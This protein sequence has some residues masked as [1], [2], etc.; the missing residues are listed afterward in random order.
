[1]PG[2]FKPNIGSVHPS[3]RGR[4]R[5]LKVVPTRL[6]SVVSRRGGIRGGRIAQPAPLSRKRTRSPSPVASG[7]TLQK[8][9]RVASESPHNSPVSQSSDGHPSF[10]PSDISPSPFHQD[11][12]PPDDYDDLYAE[13][14]LDPSS[15][16][17]LYYPESP[18]HAITPR[19]SC[20][21]SVDYERECG[22]EGLNNS[23]NTHDKQ[24][25]PVPPMARPAL[26]PIDNP[27]DPRPA[28]SPPPDP[29]SP[30]VSI[31]DLPKRQMR[32][33]PLQ[34]FISSHRLWIVRVILKL[35]TF[36]HAQ[37]HVPIRACNL[38]LATTRLIFLAKGLLDRNNSDDF[39]P[40]TAATAF[41][42]LELLQDRFHILPACSKCHALFKPSAPEN[43]TCP[44]CNIPVFQPSDPTVWE[45]LAT[46]GR[47]APPRKPSLTVPYTP[48]SSLLQDFFSDPNMIEAVE[49]W[50][51]QPPSPPGEYN[52]IMD[53]A[54]WNE[55]KCED[56]SK[57][58]DRNEHDE[59]RLGV[60]GSL[61]W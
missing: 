26:Q 32:D 9:Q 8:R 51:T 33:T 42:Y 10:P 36:L 47:K 1:M 23:P 18:T 24:D 3:Q 31:S 22:P 6:P 34:Q 56:G 38:I 15:P 46:L 14:P 21:P 39:M 53:G 54:V 11:N 2:A 5:S 58:F 19:P 52:S 44:T 43:T 49:A 20:S 45:R 4:G 30:L 48:L 13:P 60:T 28:T 29:D 55:M 17:E 40:T 37:Y 61:D 41:K 50:K 59:I 35:V 12:P 16:M 7:S 25:L 57:F 27:L